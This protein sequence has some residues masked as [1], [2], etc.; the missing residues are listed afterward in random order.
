VAD[1]L[2]ELLGGDAII[3]GPIEVTR[4]LLV[5]VAGYEGGDG[6][7]A[8]VAGTHLGALPDV[9]EEDIPAQFGEFRDRTLVWSLVLLLRHRG[10]PACP[11]P[12]S[13]G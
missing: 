10:I 13:V 12:G 2:A 1:G 6:D 9:T 5:A 8:P 7:E 11:V 4:Q 3:E